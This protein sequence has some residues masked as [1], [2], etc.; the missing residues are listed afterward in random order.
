MNTQTLEINKDSY[1][2]FDATSLRDLIIQKLNKELVFTDQN[3]VGSNISAIIEIISYSFSTLMYYLNKTSTESM[4]SEAQLYE[5]INRIVKLLGYDPIGNQTASVG[6]SLSAQNVNVDNYIIPRYSYTLLGGVPYSFVKDA[7]FTKTVNTT[8]EDFSDK[9]TKYRLY[10]GKFNEYP[11]Y[12]ASGADNE[13]IFLTLSENVVI[14][15]FN[16]DVYVK[17]NITG[18]WSQWQRVD[19]LFSY[20]SRDE[21]YEIRFNENKNYEIKFGDDI[22]GKKLSNLDTVSIFYIN[23]LR[24]QGEI[25]I[26][27]SPTFL[28]KFNSQNYN[29]ILYNT[30]TN[31]SNLI[32]DGVYKNILLKNTTASTSFASYD[33]PDTIRFK[34]PKTY[35]TQ[36]RLVTKQDYYSFIVSNFSNFI[37]DVAVVSNNEYLEKYIKY[38]Y[39]IGLSTPQLESRAL[40]NQVNFSNSCNFNNIYI[41]ALPR[42][43]DRSYL[44]PSQKEAIIEALEPLKTLTSEVVIIDPVYIAADIAIKKDLTPSLEDIDLTEIY[45]EVK[46]YSKRSNEAIRNDIRNIFASYFHRDNL[47]LGD[48]IN[49]YQLY[50]DILNIEGIDKF[51]CKSGDIIV[52]GISLIYWNPIYSEKSVEITTQNLKLPYFMYMYLNDLDQ[53]IN[54]IKFISISNTLQNI[55]I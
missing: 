30:L 7:S 19:N 21:V 11:A 53:L 47:K 17:N 14:D 4:F 16:I 25:G 54:S 22:N 3:F 55:N 31:Y 35:K 44:M 50:S 20:G 37:S 8:L 2:A 27:S 29:D 1:V 28:I 32:T 5:N 51:Y 34:A 46:R 33:S 43:K 41:I 15:H 12:T 42:T 26:V 18:V 13:I 23:S 24:E 39:D 6:F 36:N 48:T 45:V 38:F 9:V 10:Q 52:E 49:L 40:Y